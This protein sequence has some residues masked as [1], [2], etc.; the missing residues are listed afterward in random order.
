MDWGTGRCCI[1][2]H[3][4]MSVGCR[5][6]A[7]TKRETCTFHFL[8][9]CRFWSFLTRML[10]LLI[11][12]QQWI[13]G[14][15]GGAGEDSTLGYFKNKLH[16]FKKIKKRKINTTNWGYLIF[17]VTDNSKIIYFNVSGSS[18]IIFLVNFCLKYLSSFNCLEPSGN[19]FFW[20]TMFS[21]WLRTHSFK[22]QSFKKCLIKKYFS[23]CVNILKQCMEHNHFFITT[24]IVINSG[25]TALI[26]HWLALRMM[27]FVLCLFSNT[28]LF[29]VSCQSQQLVKIELPWVSSSCP[30]R[31]A[32]RLGFRQSFLGLVCKVGKK[33]EVQE[34]DSPLE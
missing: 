20:I 7:E 17:N 15:L 18:K 12:C 27:W 33:N 5:R 26:V 3:V 31:S 9:F 2:H 10:P 24:V 23:K 1:C 34:K 32:V 14:C 6:W 13:C 21:K 25:C 22:Q 11:S 8:T 30:F 29:A 28:F 19:S 4:W 16:W